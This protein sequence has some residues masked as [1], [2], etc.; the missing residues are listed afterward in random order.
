MQKV[1]DLN[2]VNI[3]LGLRGKWK[4]AVPRAIEMV[5]ELGRMKFL[6]PLYRD[7]YNSEETRQVALDTFKKNKSSYMNVAV[8][9]VQNI[10]EIVEK[11]D[12]NE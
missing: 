12:I 11:N 8:E 5:S 7:L 3:R 6:K 2:A 10:L 1:Y 9:R 4:D